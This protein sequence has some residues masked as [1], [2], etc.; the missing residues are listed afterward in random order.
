MSFGELLRVAGSG[1]PGLDAAFT[2]GTRNLTLYTQ[3]GSLAAI[4]PGHIHFN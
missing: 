4:S 2:V 3:F 1:V